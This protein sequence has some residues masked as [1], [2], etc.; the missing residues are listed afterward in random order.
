MQ[1]FFYKE[2]QGVAPLW[3]SRS[4]CDIDYICV[5]M[6]QFNPIAVLYLKFCSLKKKKSI[7]NIGLTISSQ[8]I[9]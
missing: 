5:S 7:F 2:E 4:L 6:N 3:G 9:V 8:K 1:D